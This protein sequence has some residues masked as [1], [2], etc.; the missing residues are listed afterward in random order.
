MSIVK[1]L[2]VAV[3][4]GAVLFGLVA[5]DRPSGT[6]LS[7]RLE[8]A[9]KCLERGEPNA[10]L[11]V[12]E[13]LVESFSSATAPSV[14]RRAWGALAKAATETQVWA[15]AESAARELIALAPED[16]EWRRL[17]ARA[18]YKQRRPDDAGEVLAEFFASEDGLG[19]A[20]SGETSTDMLYAEIL[21]GQY[22][23]TPAKNTLRRRSLRERAELLLRPLAAREG[24]GDTDVSLRAETA[25]ATIYEMDRDYDEAL[26]R[27]GR[28]LERC[29]ANEHEGGRTWVEAAYVKL[30][31]LRLLRRFELAG[32]LVN[33]LVPAARVVVPEY[34]PM[35]LAI[36]NEMGHVRQGQ[37][38]CAEASQAFGAVAKLSSRYTQRLGAFLVVA[39]G[40]YAMSL[41]CQG[42]VAEARA[43]LESLREESPEN[44]A[45]RY[46][47]GA[48]ISAAGEPEQALPEFY[49]AR[50]GLLGAKRME[51]ERM[52]A[53]SLRQSGK[54]GDAEREF[55]STVSRLEGS[56]AAVSGRTPVDEGLLS[57]LEHKLGE[58]RV[59]LAVVLHRRGHTEET[60]ELLR[61]A[62]DSPAIKEDLSS[63]I[64][65]R[66]TRTLAVVSRERGDF[67]NAVVLLD[68][69]VSGAENN[70]QRNAA[71]S[72][73]DRARQSWDL[74]LHGMG[75]LLS[76]SLCRSGRIDGALAA[77]ERVSQFRRSTEIDQELTSRIRA[78]LEPGE[79]FL[80]YAWEESVV[81]LIAVSST[82]NATSIRLAEGVAAVRRFREVV[83]SFRMW[84][85]ARNEEGLAENVGVSVAEELARRLIPSEIRESFLAANH[86]AIVADAPLVAVP[87]SALVLASGVDVKA[88]T[89]VLD[90]GVQVSY[91]PSIGEFL[92]SASSP[93]R[94]TS[95][96]RGVVLDDP[97]FAESRSGLRRLPA[98]SVEGEAVLG[99]LTQSGFDVERLTRR[100]ATRRLLESSAR[101]ASVVHLATHGTMATEDSPLQA[102]LALTPEGLGADDDSQLTFQRVATAWRGRLEG[103]EL[104]TLSAC[105][106]HRGPHLEGAVWSFPWVF[107]E[108]GADAVLATLW[109][110]D[111]RV[112]V[113]L[114]RQFYLGRYKR[115]ES[116]VTALTDAQRSIRGIERTAHPA[117]WA[118]F[119]LVGDSR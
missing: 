101:G 31:I 4:A 48:V 60:E 33:Q 87:F 82:G 100:R 119:V 103:C 91:A 61:A 26:T 44:A 105:D 2:S 118:G 38:R 96:R 54:L 40:N 83:R 68:R 21:L 18:L 66:A 90:E 92:N 115:G 111:D 19:A 20:S 64:A 14:R 49:A 113:D 32:E 95:F 108:A 80:R 51:A 50:D 43:I 53:I 89:F 76:D 29:R 62:I 27:L 36:L 77:L 34:D 6:A 39:R 30:R 41:A 5:F 70:R 47:L 97:V 22:R 42:F 86:V 98:S 57:V 28:V 99:V 15:L 69:A 10:A 73:W 84:V 58:A 1:A 7:F 63:S 24:D 114:I 116:L 110:I 12:L 102:A 106:T 67:E 37:E 59:D 72:A 117:Y 56:I 45:L 93:R 35:W 88:S 104:V 112:T 71:A 13:P 3:L 94:S 9:T 52:I 74:N 65:L 55:R 16:R 75:V 81:M 25:L 46:K 109:A 17:L 107:L 78:E 8:R 79:L 85:G 23:R 11:E